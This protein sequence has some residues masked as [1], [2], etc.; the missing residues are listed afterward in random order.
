MAEQTTN[1]EPGQLIDPA[2]D[3]AKSQKFSQQDDLLLATIET[4]HS[5][6]NSVVTRDGNLW[7][8]VI[9]KSWVNKQPGSWLAAQEWTTNQKPGQQVD[10]TL[11]N[12]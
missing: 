2:F 4:Y 9:V 5:F 6:R 3:F 1:Q 10:T 12:D 8:V 11:E 7:V